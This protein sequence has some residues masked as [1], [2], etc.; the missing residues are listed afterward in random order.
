MKLIKLISVH[1]RN[2]RSHPEI[3]MEFIPKRLTRILGRNG[4]GKSAIIESLGWTIFGRLRG[5]TTVQDAT[6]RPSGGGLEWPADSPWVC[7]IVEIDG[8]K[9]R[10]TR[11]KGKAS[12]EALVD[13]YWEDIASGSRKVTTWFVNDYGLQYDDFRATSWCLQDDAKRP[14]IMGKQDRMRLIR[15]LTRNDLGRSIVG[16][17]P[18]VKPKDTVREMRKYVAKAQCEL[19]QV[20][21]KLNKAEEEESSTR[22]RLDSLREK[23]K[24]IL[25][26]R[27]RHEVLDAKIAGLE[28]EAEWLRIDLD[29]CGASRR[30]IREIEVRLDDFD[31]TALNRVLTKL[32]RKCVE[33]DSLEK[34]LRGIRDK[35]LIEKSR[36]DALAD[37]HTRVVK[38]LTSAIARGQCSTCER[39][40]WT[41]Q[42]TLVAKGDHA[43]AKAEKLHRQSRR[44]SMPAAE[45]VEVSAQVQQVTEDIDILQDQVSVLRYERGYCEAAQSMLRHDQSRTER[46]AQLEVAIEEVEQSLEKCERDRKEFGYCEGEYE[47]LNRQFKCAEAAWKKATRTAGELRKTRDELD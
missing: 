29:E 8:N 5:H 41:S 16:G 44:A 47:R 15:R 39:R 20:I 42:A 7:W 19:D 46:Y 11:Q 34:S 3:N 25:E 21:E 31:S 32:T 43:Q 40:L 23:W 13:G 22:H 30:M 33:L 24:C 38:T 37:W 9:V 45:E 12:V 14:I 18:D 35:R 10:I 2:F 4:V 26:A 28:K 1:L 27:S 17:D 6:H 36:A